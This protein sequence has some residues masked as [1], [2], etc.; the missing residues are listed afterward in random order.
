MANEL[1]RKAAELHDKPVEVPEKYPKGV[2]RK[3]RTIYVSKG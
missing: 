1:M 3:Y 2:Q